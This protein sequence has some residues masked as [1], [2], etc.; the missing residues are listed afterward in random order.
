MPP[1]QIISPLD[2][3]TNGI[4]AVIPSRQIQNPALTI[5][6]MGWIVFLEEEII[7]EVVVGGGKDYRAERRRKEQLEKRKK[8][9]A[10]VFVGD[11]KF[12]KSVITKDV[13][14]S[15]K[16]VKVSISTDD[17]LR[18]KIEIILPNDQEI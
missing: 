13:K 11:E 14:L 12:T 9:T 16:D 10:T 17:K 4:L 6:T 1:N 8:I 18:P 2:I 7:E 15:L 5:A 3:A